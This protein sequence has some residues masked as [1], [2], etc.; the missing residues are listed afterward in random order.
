[1]KELLL[2]SANEFGLIA[3]SGKGRTGT[4]IAAFLIFIG[5]FNSAEEGT[6]LRIINVHVPMHRS[7]LVFCLKKEC[8]LLWHLDGITEAVR[9]DM[10]HCRL[11]EIAM[12][13][14]FRRLL[15]IR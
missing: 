3:C 7:D 8:E 5:L 10:G 12:Y 13:S 9:F 1:M 11:R 14:T 6:I 2:I 15:W 4:V